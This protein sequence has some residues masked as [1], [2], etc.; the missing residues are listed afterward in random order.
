[1]RHEAAFERRA[2]LWEDLGIGVATFGVALAV[3]VGV[4][5]WTHYVA[6]AVFILAPAILAWHSGFRPAAVV[7]ALS[8]AVTPPLVNLLDAQS[9]VINIQVRVISIGVVAL[10]V[11]WLC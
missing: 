9:S 3:V 6:G 10:V 4:G 8:T 2:S 5:L 7:A 1:M 11:A